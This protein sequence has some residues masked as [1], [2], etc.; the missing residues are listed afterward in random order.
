MGLNE[1]SD[2]VSLATLV[3]L[4]W[5]SWALENQE[6]RHRCHLE[7]LLELFQLIDINI[8]PLVVRSELVRHRSKVILD[9]LAWA[10]PRS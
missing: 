4:R 9:Q 5:H 1:L 6:G 8:D 2:L 3:L 10:T 7:E